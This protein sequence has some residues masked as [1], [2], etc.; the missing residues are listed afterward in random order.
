MGGVKSFPEHNLI[1]QV[2]NI[3]VACLHECFGHAGAAPD[4]LVLRFPPQ[5]LSYAWVALM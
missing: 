5:L 2:C 4:I 3:S 1:I